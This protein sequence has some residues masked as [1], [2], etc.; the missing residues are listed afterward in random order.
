MDRASIIFT[1]ANQTHGNSGL[2]IAN[3]M[4][5]PKYA[6]LGENKGLHFKFQK[7]EIVYFPKPEECFLVPK[8]IGTQEVLHIPAYSDKRKRYIQ[9]PIPV[10]RRI[11]VYDEE[12][13]EFFNL[14][15]RAFN[16][17]LAE[18]QYDVDRALELC[19]IGAIECKDIY[20]MHRAWIE[21]GD[22][23]QWHRIE[24]KDKPLDMYDIQP[25]P[26]NDI[27]ETKETINS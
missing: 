7:G 17:L 18:M 22:D 2:T 15:D 6:K 8:K 10:F 24:G 1:E 21:L 23:K 11:P 13:N 26:Q 25:I 14:E 3:V 16:V 5:T 19:R 9:I 4:K 12:V 27:E 20:P